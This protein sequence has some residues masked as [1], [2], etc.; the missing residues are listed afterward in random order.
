MSAS[1]EPVAVSKKA[2]KESG[3]SSSAAPAAQKAAVVDKAD[4]KTPLFP[5]TP[6]WKKVP[7][8]ERIVFDAACKLLKE[9]ERKREKKKQKNNNF[10]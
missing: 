3:S 2:S 8:H 9:R 4:A 7:L 5:V 10:C 1:S 6:D